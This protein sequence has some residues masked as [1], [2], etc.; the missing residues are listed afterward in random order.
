MSDVVGAPSE[1]EQAAD[2]SENDR[3]FHGILVLTF[4]GLRKAFGK[5]LSGLDLLFGHLRKLGIL[6]RGARTSGQ[7]KQHG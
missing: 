4:R 6:A 2:R 1:D 7:Q 3:R 5:I